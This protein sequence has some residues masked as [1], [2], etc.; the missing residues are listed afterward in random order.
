MK[1]KNAETE[2]DQGRSEPISQR[3]K[4]A[5]DQSRSKIFVVNEETEKLYA[6]QQ[7]TDKKRSEI[8]SLEKKIREKQSK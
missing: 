3:L 2:V 1:L 5:C 7:G 4:E 6:L 8:L